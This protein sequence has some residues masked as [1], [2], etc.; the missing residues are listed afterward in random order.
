[1]DLGDWAC[2]PSRIEKKPD[3]WAYKAKPSSSLH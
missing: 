1:M 2:T 3:M